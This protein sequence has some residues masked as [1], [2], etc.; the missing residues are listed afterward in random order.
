MKRKNLITI[1]K[2]HSVSCYVEEGTRKGSLG[3]FVGELL[4][5]GECARGLYKLGAAGYYV[6][7]GDKSFEERE[8]WITRLREIR[9][10][11]RENLE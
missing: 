10:F 5:G 6:G 4:D 8:S 7:F 1:A 11:A 2:H 3:D 9:R